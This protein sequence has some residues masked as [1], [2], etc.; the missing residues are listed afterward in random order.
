MELSDFF[1]IFHGDAVSVGPVG[2]N[3]SDMTDRNQ[4]TLRWYLGAIL[5]GG[6]VMTIALI[7]FRSGQR[8]ADLPE[9][10]RVPP[11]TLVAETGDT[12]D[13]S[14][15]Q[16]KVS[17]VDFVFTS[18]A[19]ICPMMSGTMAYMQ[20]E[21]SHHPG[22]QLVSFSVDPETDTPEVLREYGERY[23]AI[24][25]R[26]TFLTG[27][28]PLIYDITRTGFHLGVET[29]GENAIIHS[30]KFVLVDRRGAI[31]GY[32]DSDSTDAIDALQ[33]DAIFLTEK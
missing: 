16:D 27:P 10:G 5:A 6:L 21:F 1:H 31:R 18:C 2:Q 17:V 20:Q 9:L 13:Q 4:P 26:W 33:E 22:I 28:K 3:T 24:P 15:F 7:L 19:G 30:Q 23:G 29:Q 8:H 14:L 12:V 11:F 25:G 32:Y